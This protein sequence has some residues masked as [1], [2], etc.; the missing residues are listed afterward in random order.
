GFGGLSTA[1]LLRRGLPMEYE[2]TVV[3]K[4]DYFMMGFVN[5]WIM[6][7]SRNFKESRHSLKSLEKKGINFLN[8]VIVDINCDEKSVTISKNKTKIC[9]DYLIVS[10]GADY[11]PGTITGLVDNEC[12]NLYDPEQAEKIRDKV[13]ALKEGKIAICITS[14]PYKC[15]PAPFEAALLVNSMLSKKGTRNDIKINIYSPS[16]V[17]LPVAKEDVN[18]DILELLEKNKINFNGGYKLT[19]VSSKVTSIFDHGSKREEVNHDLL[20]YIPPHGLPPVL[21]SSGLVNHDQNWIEVDKF[22]LKTIY[23]N[24]FAIGDSVNIRVNK[25]ISIPKAGIFAE[26]QAKA[27][28]QQII[29]DI[30]LSKDMVTKY[31]GK[32]FCFMETGDEN[33]GLIEANFY[34]EQGPITKL[35]PA[36]KESFQK[37]IEFEQSRLDT[38]L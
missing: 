32:G 2:I 20:I 34:S 26:G 5:L 29:N 17:P 1:H 37:K 18:Q 16:L 19:E 25:E 3:D 22:T 6:Y 36:S 14:F 31:E 13:L 9:Y 7:G 28:S 27:V 23:D 24:V 10:L 30:C 35:Y 12:L 21:K 8:D 4:K 11:F 15:P 38:W 33:A